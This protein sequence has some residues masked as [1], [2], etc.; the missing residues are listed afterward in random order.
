VRVR[1]FELRLIGAT[2]LGCWTVAALL[3]LLSYR[4]GGPLD[5]VV[6]LTMVIPVGV[7]AA[8]MVWPPVTRGDRAHTAVVCLGVAALLCLIPSI[9]GLIGQLVAQGS[10]TLLPSLEAAYPWLLALLA[11]SLFAGIGLARRIQGGNALRRR[12][13]V[14]SVVFALGLTLLAGTLFAS[15]AVANELALRDAAA[16]A[17]RFGPTAVDGD[18]PPCDGPLAA[19]PGARLTSRMYATIDLRPSGSVELSGTR[20]GTDFRWI[21]YVATPA[22]LGQAGTAR[23]GPEAWQ[24]PPGGRWA[25]ASASEAFQDSVDLRVLQTALTT[26]GRAIF[27]DRG[28]EVI[29]G[30]RARH[31]RIAVDGETFGA[32]FPQ[33]RWLVGDADL[34]RWR[35]QLDFWV[36]LD[37]QLGQVAGSASGEAVGMDPDALLATVEVLMTATSRDD[38]LVIYP[39]SP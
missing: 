29:E 24:R 33:I 15:A 21:A 5:V 31:C 20:A 30:A 16:V 18:P 2:L 39:P 28:V 6:G 14:Q 32:A 11:T 27:E 8:A 17:S 4:P 9:G 23:I 10:Q 38:D 12:R 37:G 3:V 35:G 36:F 13:L 19:G 7:A 22:E 1:S 26:A 25:A 34:H